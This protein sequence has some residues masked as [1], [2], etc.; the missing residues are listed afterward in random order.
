MDIEINEDNYLVV[1][2]HH[3][4][5]VQ[6]NTID[7][8]KA[9]MHRIMCIKK[10]IDRYF[11]SGKMNLQLLLNHTIVLHNAFGK[12][13]EK[14]LRLRLDEKYHPAIKSVLVYLKYIESDDWGHV[15]EDVNILNELRNI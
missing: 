4:D 12:V 7:E 14:L 13:A 8:F 6:C 11:A 5:N 2:M 9:D 3:Y 1:A 10:L 15:F